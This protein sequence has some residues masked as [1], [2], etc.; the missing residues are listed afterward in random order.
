VKI[1]LFPLFSYAERYTI[2][3]DS[4]GNKEEWNEIYKQDEMNS[5]WKKFQSFNFLPRTKERKIFLGNYS[6]LG[7]FKT[8][9][10][11]A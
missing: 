4:D 3:F 5:C 8:M 6:N 7:H 1:F 9:L 2:R 11:V 10:R